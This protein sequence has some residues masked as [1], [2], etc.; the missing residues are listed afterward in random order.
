MSKTVKYMIASINL[1]IFGVSIY[2]NYFYASDGAISAMS[3]EYMTLLT[4]AD[5]AFSIWGLIYT[6]ALACCV[7]TVHLSRALWC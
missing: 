2:I 4:P 7:G 6:L 3:D 5:Y 1:I